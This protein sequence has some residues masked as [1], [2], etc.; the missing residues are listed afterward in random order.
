M[1]GICT[2][3]DPWT[4][5]CYLPLLPEKPHIDPPFH[6]CRYMLLHGITESPNHR[7]FRLKRRPKHTSHRH[8]HSLRPSRR[9]PTRRRR[10]SRR[11]R[12]SAGS[13]PLPLALTR[14]GSTEQVEPERSRGSW[15]GRAWG[16]RSS[17]VRLMADED[18][19]KG[20]SWCA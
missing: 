8:C 20:L 16:P 12:L 11:R 15:V 6:S 1:Q 19:A 3:T 5:L 18:Q 9:S 4:P 13:A 2:Y 17:H 10:V 7:E 14:V